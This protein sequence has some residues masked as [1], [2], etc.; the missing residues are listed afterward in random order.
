[1]VTAFH[2]LQIVSDGKIVSGKA[3]LIAGDQITAIVDEIAIP[4]H[5]NKIDLH[6]AFVAPGLID[7][8]L[9]G[10]GGKLLSI[11][12]EPAT[13][14]QMENDLLEQGTTGFFATI[15]TNTDAVIEQ[16]ISVARD[17]QENSR[18]NFLGLH[19]EG[20]FIN[21]LRNGAH[22]KNY[23]KKASLSLVKKWIE[24]ADGVIK[25]M[26]IAPELQDQ[27]V[28]D[29]LHSSGVILSSG[30]S[31]ATYAEG[32]A[33]LNKP[34][35]AVTHLFNAMPQMHHRN[36]G[37][38]PAIFEEKPYTSIVPDGIHVDFVMARMAKRE[39]GDKLFFITDSV[40]VTN[41]GPYQHQ[42]TGDRYVMP[43]GTLSGS[44]LTMLKAV[45]NGVNHF[46]IDLPES[47]NMASLYPA[48]LAKMPTKGKVAQ[49]YDADLIVFN[50]DFEVQGT[51]FKGNY[52]TKRT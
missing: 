44:C 4:N 41:H 16:T 5:T 6:G 32:K 8:Q 43:D 23:I 15:S 34:I 39:L 19:L 30:H 21:P 52:L 1:M 14:L 27:E 10:S 28:I 7:L 20:P 11:D 24:M 29:Y 38:I 22:N 47:V 13:L 48:Q 42:F 25:M 36:P 2:N 50:A 12:T 31:N 3:V 33:F 17:Y 51:V 35:P 9:Y 37:Y 26:T 46:G 49:G 18:G 40:T 45:Q